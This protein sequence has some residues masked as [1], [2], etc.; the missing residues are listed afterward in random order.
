MMINVQQISFICTVAI[1]KKY[2][3]V[4]CLDLN[5]LFQGQKVYFVAVWRPL[6]SDGQGSIGAQTP[7]QQI[8]LEATFFSGREWL[9]LHFLFIIFSD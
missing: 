7:P 2:G 3:T 1:H 8:L 6:P 5:M 9:I 4:C